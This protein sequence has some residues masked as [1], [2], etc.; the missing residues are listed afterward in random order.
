MALNKLAID[1]LNMANKRVLMRVDFNVPLKEGKITNNQRIV[2]ALDSVNYVLEKKAKSIVLMSHLGRP[3]GKKNDKYSL[4]PVAEELKKLLN[5]DILFLPDC[6]G[7]E[8]ESA[9]EDP[10]PGSVILLEN[11]RFHIEEEGKGVDESGKK[12]KADPEKVKQFRASLRKLGDVYVNDAFGTAHRAHSSMMGEGFDERAAGFLLKK[13][14][15][16]FAKALENPEKPFLAIL[17]GAKVADKIQL[18]ENLLDKVSEMIIGGGMAFTFLKQLHSMK[19]GNSLF[20]EKGAEIVPKLMDKAK[21]NGVQIHLPVDFVV[22]DSFC[23]DAKKAEA[24]LEDGIPDGWMGLDIGPKSYRV[25]DEAILKAKVI[26]WN[27]PPGVF[28]FEQFSC[29]TKG[30]LESV[31]KAT[32]NG[33]ITI[34]GGGDTATVAA[35]Y[36]AEDKVSHVS[37]GGGASLELLEGKTLPGVAAL[38][39]A[40]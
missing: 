4:K 18:I 20:D 1:S 36:N 25:F 17:G 27:G 26:V 31:I 16:Y 14:L 35:K 8:V 34:I 23:E 9:C 39:D 38:S 19:I 30:M 6:V 22:G 33:A 12:I 11:L 37:T 40:K 29:G 15:T 32:E 5:R 7:P 3:D 13:E 10:K 28:E 21:T 2:A 24:T